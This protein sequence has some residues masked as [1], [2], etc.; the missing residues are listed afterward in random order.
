[1]S[2]GVKNLLS[3]FDQLDDKLPIN[4]LIDSYNYFKEPDDLFNP[5][6]VSIEEKPSYESIP[7]MSI[8]IEN[9]NFNF[10]F[11]FD[12][13]Q[14]P[15]T[16][17]TIFLESNHIDHPEIKNKFIVYQSLS[18]IGLWR[19]Y[20]FNYKFNNIY[21][22]R[23]DYIQQTMINVKLQHYLDYFFKNYDKECNNIFSKY[24]NDYQIS[25]PKI[26]KHID[27]QSRQIRISPFID[28]IE[29]HG[30]GNMN[31]L[32]TVIRLAKLSGQIQ[33]NYDYNQPTIINT[34]DKVIV[35]DYD[36]YNTK[37][38]L[39]GIIYSTNLIDKKDTNN[40]LILY[41]I[42]YNLDIKSDNK[43]NGEIHVKN[44]YAPIIL[45]KNDIITE[46][47]T[48]Q[49]YVLAGAYICKIL[50]YNTLTHNQCPKGTPNCSYNYG[51]IGDIYNIIYPYREII[52]KN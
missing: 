19:L 3:L 29:N 8:V 48:Y 23:E 52:L 39:N 32:A 50:D 40:Q 13:T 1:M 45:I 35:L 7:K 6:N 37:A 27:N 17:N 9:Y 42:K 11:N 36:L 49:N 51:Y 31:N 21:K 43:K 5:D 28:D 22:G 18:E 30:C 41:Y 46:Y 25:R 38:V 4:K 14:V 44:Y 26:L 20:Y 16:R 34:I 12:F 33:S 24:Y 10:C 15:Y 47:G 2:I